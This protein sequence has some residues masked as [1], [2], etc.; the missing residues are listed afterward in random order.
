MFRRGCVPLFSRLGLLFA[1]MGWLCCNAQ[2]Q[3][4]PSIASLSPSSGVVGTT[5]TINGNNFGYPQGSSSLSFGGNSITP[6]SWGNTAIT[7][8][9]PSGTAAGSTSVYVTVG[10]QQSNTALFTVQ[11]APSINR[12]GISPSS[13]AVGTTVTI[14]GNNFGA[15]QGTSTVQF[16][17]TPA[18]VYGYWSN[19]SIQVIV[20]A[21]LA[22]GDY[23]VTVTVGGLQSNLVYF[24]VIPSLSVSPTT[25]SVL[26]GGGTFA[27]QVTVNAA[28]TATSDSSWLQLNTTSGSGNGSLEYQVSA[29]QSESPQTGT[30][31]VSSQGAVATIA[32]TEAGLVTRGAPTVSVVNTLANQATQMVTLAIGDP[33]GPAWLDSVQIVVDNYLNWR[34]YGAYSCQI[35]YFPQYNQLYFTDQGLSIGYTLGTAGQAVGTHCILDVGNSSASFNN[36]S[37]TA[38]LTLNLVLTLQPSALG[39]QNVYAYVTDGSGVNSTYWDSLATWPAAFPLLTSNPPTVTMD[40]PPTP[41]TASG[42]MLH[43]EIS[44]GN[45]YTFLNNIQL[46]LVDGQGNYPCN[47][48]FIFPNYIELWQT[49]SGYNM[50]LLGAGLVNGGGSYTGS[51]GLIGGSGGIPGTGTCSI[52]FNQSRVYTNPSTYTLENPN[53]GGP[54]TNLYLD[55]YTGLDATGQ[56]AVPLTIQGSVSDLLQQ[57]SQVEL[58]VWYATVSD[59]P[60]ASDSTMTANP[61]SVPADNSTAATVTVTLK[62]RFGN[63]VSGRAVTVT[64]GTGH[65]YISSSDWVSNGSGVVTFTVV[66]GTTE[67][68]T[69]AAT[70]ATD[71][72]NVAQTAT[73]IFGAPT[74]S[75]LAPTSGAVTT[76][77]TITGTN[78]GSSQGNSTVTFN[79]TEGQAITRRATISQGS[80]TVSFNTASAGTVMR[81]SPTSITVA[82]PSG[83]A[84]GNNNVVVTVNAVPS[85]ASSFTVMPGSSPGPSKEYIL[86]GGRVIAIE[87]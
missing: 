12:Y 14:T 21:G 64:Q 73:V 31:T 35:Q 57:Q 11:A 75:R 63:P 48:Y 82:V 49:I 85:N 74:I 40:P 5:V 15:S 86:L 53:S 69:Y 46:Q 41:T 62:D 68:V 60:T 27:A 54:H 10:G 84:T 26:G 19:T 56:A 51:G 45:G 17:S 6:D 24:T 42:Q 18:T 87:N 8:T 71:L 30:I 37:T 61:T 67:A 36:L 39:A 29:N 59:V 65:S 2:A 33:N 1:A 58:G 72:V 81:W 47:V 43:Y 83:A 44:D 76:P 79:G 16:Y 80:S 9:V 34:T 7:F 20:P 52:D 55:L 4:A 13:G 78:F 23:V 25:Q 66:D 77:V 3:T 70:D 50:A 32:V 22:F 28:W 38:G